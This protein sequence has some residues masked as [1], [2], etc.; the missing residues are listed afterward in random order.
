M[1]FGLLAHGNTEAPTNCRPEVKMPTPPRACTAGCKWLVHTI[2]HSVNHQP[3]LFTL[4][5]VYLSNRLHGSFPVLNPAEK[6]SL[7]YGNFA[8]QPSAH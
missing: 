4:R 7:G 6:A 2:T 3:L 8:A 1:V 5:V